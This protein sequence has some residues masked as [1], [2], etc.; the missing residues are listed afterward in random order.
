MEK[1]ITELSNKLL[2]L[3]LKLMYADFGVNIKKIYDD[4]II[5]SLSPLDLNL[6]SA[7]EITFLYELYKLNY[8]KIDDDTI[9]ESNIIKPTLKKFKIIYYEDI[10][11]YK[12]YEYATEI[13]SYTTDKSIIQEVFTDDQKYEDSV[14]DNLYDNL[15]SDEVLD[16]DFSNSDIKEIKLIDEENK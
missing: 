12:R 11:E 9:R 2:L 13:E 14:R 4:S 16:S 7:Q 15:I 5:E 6:N 1:K 3:A 8:M 10:T